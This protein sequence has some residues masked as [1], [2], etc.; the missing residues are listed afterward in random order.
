MPTVKELDDKINEL[1]KVGKILD[2]LEAHYADHCTFQEGNQ[3]PRVGRAA[4]H[5][6]LSDFFATLKGFNGATLHSQGVGDG[7]TLTEWT[8]DMDGP[9]GHILWNEVLRRKWK[10]GKVVS[11]RFYTS[12]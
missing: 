2:A 10:D 11:E 5:Q 7:V 6:H 3:A 4:Q 12:A 9:D 8:F 1:T